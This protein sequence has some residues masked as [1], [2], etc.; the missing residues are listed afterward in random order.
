[1]GA[2]LTKYRIKAKTKAEAEKRGKAIA[3]STGIYKFDY[4]EKTVTRKE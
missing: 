3:D 4:V 2:V 1:M